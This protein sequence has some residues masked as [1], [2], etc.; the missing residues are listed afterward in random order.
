MARRWTGQM[1]RCCLAMSPRLRM[2]SWPRQCGTNTGWSQSETKSRSGIRLNKA[3]YLTNTTSATAAS[4]KRGETDNMSPSSMPTTSD[5]RD[6]S[7]KPWAALWS[8]SWPAL[9]YLSDKERRR[10]ES[11]SLANTTL[12]VSWGGS[13]VA[14]RIAEEVG[15]LQKSK[16]VLDVRL[17]EQAR[18]NLWFLFSERHPLIESS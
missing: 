4:S 3:Q 1:R 7:E 16:V 15:M 12:V 8:T 10:Q 6:V 17:Q 18:S 11:A 9:D 2:P 14:K 13:P 5:N